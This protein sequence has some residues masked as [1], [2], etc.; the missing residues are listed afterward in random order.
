MQLYFTVDEAKKTE[1]MQ[2]VQSGQ[3]LQR[4]QQRKRA[5]SCRSSTSSMSP[6]LQETDAGCA[7]PAAEASRA[8][9][10]AD[11]AE[12]DT[13]TP[14]GNGEVASEGD[15]VVS[16]DE[17]SKKQQRKQPAPQQRRQPK[18]QHRHG[19]VGKN[20][21]LS[22]SAKDK[23]WQFLAEGTPRQDTGRT[24]KVSDFEW[25]NGWPA[26]IRAAADGVRAVDG[27]NREEFSD[28]DI[29]KAVNAY[30]VK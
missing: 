25:Q 16:D 14:A 12:A 4:K 29:Y 3:H 21:R 24:L 13:A 26:L 19:T 18:A 30:A 2:Q 7:Q 10:D 8:G 27:L 1:I 11:V 6:G 5:R 9:T 22:D 28:A 17:Q 15:W 20:L 23:V